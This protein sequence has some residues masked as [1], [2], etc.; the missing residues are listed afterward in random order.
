MINQ[1]QS[2]GHKALDFFQRL[3]RGHILIVDVLKGQPA[4]FFAHV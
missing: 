4:L 3:G 1:L 2:L